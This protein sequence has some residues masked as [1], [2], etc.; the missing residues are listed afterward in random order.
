MD[1]GNSMV[2][3]M[4]LNTPRVAKITYYNVSAKHEH[5]MLALYWLKSVEQPQV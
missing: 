4:A 3:K 1:N 2:V 5:N